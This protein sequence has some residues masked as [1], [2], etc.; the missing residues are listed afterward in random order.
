MLLTHRSVLESILINIAS[1]ALAP[2]KLL[3]ELTG[4]QEKCVFYVVRIITKNVSFP[5]GPGLG[6][7]L[8]T[9]KKSMSNKQSISGKSG[10]VNNQRSVLH[11]LPDL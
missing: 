8:R 7:S 6:N 1:S 9:L 10:G 5:F 3:L 2:T 4:N 11:H